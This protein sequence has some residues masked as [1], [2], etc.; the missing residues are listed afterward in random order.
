MKIKIFIFKFTLIIIKDWV[1]KLLLLDIVFSFLY[2]IYIVLSI[3]KIRWY[4]FINIFVFLKEFLYFFATLFLGYNWCDDYWLFFIYFYMLFLFLLWF[5]FLIFV[6]SDF[7]YN[8]FNVFFS[9]L[10]CLL[11]Y[12]K[13]NLV[14]FVLKHHEQRD[15]QNLYRYRDV[16]VFVDWFML[17]YITF[18]V[19]YGRRI[20]F[21]NVYLRYLLVYI[22]SYVFVSLKSNYITIVSSSKSHYFIIEL[23]LFKFNFLGDIFTFMKKNIWNHRLALIVCFCLLFF[24]FSLFYPGWF[25]DLSTYLANLFIYLFTSLVNYGPIMSFLQWFLKWRFILLWTFLIIYFLI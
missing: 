11:G 13:I 17:N 21:L 18:M 14:Y 6:T 12:L 15:L 16:R 2:Y 7:F 3:L 5:V 25:I 10:Y 1:F 4:S 23:K 8:I 9:L 22:S 19:N 20:L 24:Q